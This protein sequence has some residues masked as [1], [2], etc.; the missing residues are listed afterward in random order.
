VSTLSSDDALLASLEGTVIAPSG[1]PGVE[2]RLERIIGA[3]SFSVAFFAIRS[4][5]DG[6]SP[7]VIKL[8]RPR[9]VREAGQAAALVAQKERVALRRLNEQVPPPPFVVRL[10]DDD[11][12][13][14]VDGDSP[15]VLPWLA[16]EYVHGGPEGTTLD[17]RIDFSIEQTGF[18]FEPERV[19]LALRC[20]AGGLDAIHRVGVVHR[21]LTPWNVLCCGFGDDEIFK[22]SDFGVARPRGGVGTFVGFPVGTPGYAAPEQVGQR[23]GQVGPASDVF[24]LAGIVFKMLTGTPYFRVDNMPDA[25]LRAHENTRRSIGESRA[26]HPDIAENAAACRDIDAALARATSADPRDRPQTSWEFA[27]GILRLLRSEGSVS[28]PHR[29]RLE[30]I[31]EESRSAKFRWGWR[32][33]HAALSG[34]QIRSVAWDGDG[35]CLAATSRGLSFWNGTT[36]VAVPHAG[37]PNPEGIRFVH[38]VAAGEWLLGGD[39]ATIA[40]YSSDGVSGV[41][42]AEN[43]V[44]FTHASG[45][46]ADLAVLVGARSGE[47][48]LMFSV[49]ARRWLKPASLSKAQAVTSL[50][51]LADDRWLLAGRSLSG[52]GFAAIYTPLM[53]EVRRLRSDA[54]TYLAC[55]AQPEL[56]RGAAVGERGRVSLVDGESSTELAVPGEPDLSAVAVDI[57]GRVWVGGAGRLWLHQPESAE[58]WACQ[59]QSTV[60]RAPIV[61]IF[62]DLGLV[63]AMTADGAV[64]EGRWERQG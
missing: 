53:F 34:I 10:L 46:P 23:T 2:Y 29:Q 11:A 62:A 55:A 17:D 42:R 30:S 6:E 24:S 31:A 26:L 20:L 47:P 61:S 32:V 63:T 44:T 28:R 5:S 18:A 13:R 4:S 43:P 36:W 41:V 33:R 25:M 45:E 22:I 60:E 64:L 35:H 49:A 12:V 19:A 40:H 9:M 59:W 48:P 3:G 57:A 58:A 27:A 8:M 15:A 39:D 50:A 37:L 52:R 54:D 14:V 21:D 51:R 38:R 56:G 16:L 1:R 7:A